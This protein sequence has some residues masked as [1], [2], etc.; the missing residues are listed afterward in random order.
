MPLPGFSYN[1]FFRNTFEIEPEVE[2]IIRPGIRTKLRKF[3]WKM[4]DIPPIREEPY[5][6]TNPGR[7][8]GSAAFPI[9]VF[10]KPV[11]VY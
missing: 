1:V 2:D 4:V 9:G 10:Q 8:P 7:L 6:R 3:N 5:M 11:S